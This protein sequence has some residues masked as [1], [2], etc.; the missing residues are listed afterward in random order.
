MSKK[1]LSDFEIGYKYAQK[2]S[3]FLIKNKPQYF[4]KLSRA[5]FLDNSVTSE[6]SR[7]MGTYFLEFGINTILSEASLF[8]Q[9]GGFEN[10]INKNEPR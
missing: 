9:Y 6:L 3:P 5:Y 4:L 7:G 2:L 10:S 8:E 1:C